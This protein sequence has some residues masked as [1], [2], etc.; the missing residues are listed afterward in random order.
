MSSKTRSMPPRRRSHGDGRFDPADLG[1]LG[2]GVV[3][4][5]GVMVFHPENVRIGDHVYVGHQTIV[6]GYHQNELVIGAGCWIGQQCFFHG[7]GGLTLGENVGVGPGVTI[8]TS[9]HR[10]A[11]REVPILHAP[12]E[13]APVVV[14]DDCDLG[15]G[16]ILLPGVTLGRG[17]QLGAGAV[18]SADLPDYAVAAGVPAKVLRLRD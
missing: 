8:I 2:E 5:R 4:E 11:G 18:V 15:V 13:F 9:T 7:G 3:F 16:A 14:G 6:K 17:V 10:E 12:V 1:E